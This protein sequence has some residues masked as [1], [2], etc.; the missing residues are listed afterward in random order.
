MQHK[1]MTKFPEIWQKK[2][3]FD[4]PFCAL[5]CNKQL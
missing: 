3:K 2:L 1:F 5:L 4:A